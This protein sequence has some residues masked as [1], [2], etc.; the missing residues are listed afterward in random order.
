MLRTEKYIVMGNPVPWARPGRT[1]CS[2]AAY[3]TQKREKEAYGWCLRT[4]RGHEELWKGPI[5]VDIVFYLKMNNNQEARK[6]ERDQQPHTLIPD[7]DNLCKFILDAASN[8]VLYDDDRIV[9]RITAIKIWDKVPR[10]EMT[11]TE[12][13]VYRDGTPYLEVMPK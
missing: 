11:I 9:S 5:H 4:P 6:A 12:M 8:G 3:D 2:T 7:L 10:T 13:N 1:R